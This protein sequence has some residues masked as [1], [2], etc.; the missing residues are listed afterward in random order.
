MNT[1]IKGV[2]TETV[3]EIC[4]FNFYITWEDENTGYDQRGI[5]WTNR[6]APECSIPAIVDICMDTFNQIMNGSINPVTVY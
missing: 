5:K 3:V 4:G 2:K 6:S 1:S